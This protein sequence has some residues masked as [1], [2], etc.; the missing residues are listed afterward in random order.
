MSNVRWCHILR[1]VI[2]NVKCLYL[3]LENAL[4]P[5]VKQTLALEDRHIFCQTP[6]LT[7]CASQSVSAGCSL[8]SAAWLD[9]PQAL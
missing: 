6:L 1:F 2:R 3:G 8:F 9:P 7:L 4:R 5:C